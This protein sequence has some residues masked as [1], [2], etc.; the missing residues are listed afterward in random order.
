MFLFIFRLETHFL[1][2][3][4]LGINIDFRLLHWARNSHLFWGH[5]TYRLLASLVISSELNGN[6]T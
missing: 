1:S 3:D 5:S 2:G 4:I 6:I